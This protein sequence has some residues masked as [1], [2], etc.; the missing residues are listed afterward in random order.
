MEFHTVFV[1][2]ERVASMNAI[3]AGAQ[4]LFTNYTA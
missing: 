2:R 4:G 3:A 1:P